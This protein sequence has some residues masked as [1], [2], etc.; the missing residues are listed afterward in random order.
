MNKWNNLIPLVMILFPALLAAWPNYYTLST[1]NFQVYYRKG[2]STEAL[3]LLQALE[4]GKP[5]V[6]GLTGHDPGRIPVLM[7]DMGNLV[8]GYASPAGRVMAVFAYPPSSDEL[9]LGEDW[10]QQVGVHE[11]IHMSQMTKATAEPALL[12][13]LFG[14]ILYPNLYQPM[15]MTEGITVYGESQLSKHGGRL[16]SGSYS[17]VINALAR[18]SKLPS[19]GKACYYS[20]SNPQGNYYVYGSSFYQYLSRK[21]GEDKFQALFADTGASLESY[22][23]PIYSGLSLDKA[24]ARVYGKPVTELWADWQAEMTAKATPLPQNKV[25]GDG[26]QTANLQY[27][28]GSLYYTNFKVSKTGPSSTFSSHRLIRIADPAGKAEREIL[29]EQGSDF[30]AGYHVSEDRLYY[31]DAEYR[32]GFANNAYDGLG[33]ISRIWEMKLDGSGRRKLAEGPIRAFYRLDDGQL[34]ISE[35]DPTHQR[36]LLS[37]VDPLSGTRTEIGTIDQL[38]GTIHQS[39]G[40]TIVTARKFWQN[41]SIFELDL[42][43]L[44]LSPLVDTPN[45]ETVSYVSGSDL[46]F[47]AVYDNQNGSYVYNL[48]GGGISQFAGFSEVKHAAPAP[49]GQTYF[50]SQNAKGQDV[51][52]DQLKLKPFSPPA[53]RASAPAYARLSDSGQNKVLNKFEVQRGTYWS[54]IGHLLWPRLYR[55]PY[56]ASKEAENTGDQPIGEETVAL[57]DLI[58]GAQLAG[59]DVVGDFP[60][61]YATVLY[62]IGAE[63]WGYSLGLINNFF[64]PLKHQLEYSNLDGKSLSSLQYVPILTRMNYGLKELTAGFGYSVSEEPGLD[65]RSLLYPYLGAGF[66]YRGLRLATTNLLLYEDTGKLG[67]DRDRLGWQGNFNLRLKAP[68]STELRSNIQAAWDP[69]ADPDEVFSGG[70][71]YSENWLTRS[72][73]Q[74]KNSWYAPLLKIRNGLWAPNLY[75]EDVNLGLFYDYSTPWKASEGE[76]RSAYGAELIAEIFAGYNFN[77][78]L[79]LRYSVNRSEESMLSLILEL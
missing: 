60:Q 43:T 48:N 18:E 75:I 64:R 26:W 45:M 35:D 65:R 41:N 36:S 42:N 47:D 62:D 76:L 32:R 55:M 28:D 66:A 33:V 38:I 78:N 25:S 5:Y 3:N 29:V 27:H 21:Y 7:E 17:A 70:R 30:P 8:N 31:S 23:N 49:G 9:A 63:D 24:Y 15:W 16:N 69:D 68:L 6:D 4:Y 37:K 71:G 56:I 54:N 61:W 40:R 39:N 77:L 52:R 51:Y 53:E 50:V 58:V 67:S 2:W 20:Y 1:D 10:W 79:G 11:Y 19:A 72:G 13:A 74:I 22:L 14:N 59:G 12:R 73:A 46:I 57:N 44:M 34:L